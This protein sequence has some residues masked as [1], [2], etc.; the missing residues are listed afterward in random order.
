MRQKYEND[1]KKQILKE[2][3]MEQIRHKQEL[4]DRKREEKILKIKERLR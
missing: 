1:L 3:Q 4:E 2:E